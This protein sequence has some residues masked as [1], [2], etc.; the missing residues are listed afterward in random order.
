M[1]VY[2][3]GVVCCCFTATSN[4]TGGRRAWIDVPIYYIHFVICAYVASCDFAFLKF[5]YITYRGKKI[6][7]L[8]NIII[9][10]TIYRR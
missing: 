9:I 4:G 3:E 7:Y 2:R 5:D 1:R 6:P 8:E 10:Y